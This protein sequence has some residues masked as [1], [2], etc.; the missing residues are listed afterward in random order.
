MSDRPVAGTSTYTTNTRDKHPYPNEIRTR[1]PSNLAAADFHITP[2]GHRDRPIGIRTRDP[3]IRAATGLLLTPHGSGI[4]LVQTI[5]HQIP[6]VGFETVTSILS[7]KN[8]QIVP[9]TFLPQ[10]THEKRVLCYA[11]H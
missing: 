9:Y 8:T 6:C 5:A 10:S 1:D 7:S 4:V 3:S 11:K 2:H